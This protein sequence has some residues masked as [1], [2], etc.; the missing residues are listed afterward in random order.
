VTLTEVPTKGSKFVGW[1]DACAPRKQKA[2]CV[3]DMKKNRKVTAV[4]AKK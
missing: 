1:G 3:V 4:F 2:T